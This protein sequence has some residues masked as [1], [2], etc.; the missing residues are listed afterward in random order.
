MTRHTIIA[1]CAL[2]SFTLVGCLD[3]GETVYGES[4]PDDTFLVVYD[5]SVGVHPSQ[6]VL[7]DPNNP[8]RLARSGRDT[9]FEIEA[10]DSHNVTAFY[11]W[12]TW[13]ATEPTG[14]SQF[15]TAS[16]LAEIWRA[17]DAS[18]ED[19]ALIRQM[20]IDGFQ[21]VLDDFPDAATFDPT[22]NIRFELITPSYQGIIALGGTPE[23]SWYLINDSNGI[24]RAVQP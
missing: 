14:E 1:L 16:N 4:F 11:S 7:S 21:A 22:G 12:A 17:G 20:A 5:T 19:L 15:Y 8:F 6:A 18:Q 9:R 10:N 2:A 24:P 23:G 3:P 13:L